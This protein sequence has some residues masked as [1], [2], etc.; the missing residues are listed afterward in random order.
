V[1]KATPLLLEK[2]I[3]RSLPRDAHPCRKLVF[4]IKSHD[5][6]WGGE[7]EDRGTY[8]GSFTWFDVGK[9]KIRA[10]D[11]DAQPELQRRVEGLRRPEEAARLVSNADQSSEW[12]GWDS[13]RYDLETI[14]P[15]F[16][17]R[18]EKEELQRWLSDAKLEHPPLPH[19]RML[20]KNL[21]AVREMQDREIVWR[22]DDDAQPEM[23]EAMG[24]GP[25]TGN[26]DFV[27]SLEI[28]DVV[29]VWARARFPGWANIAEELRVDMYWAV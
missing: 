22:W 14:D 21:T 13:L 15:R 29:T 12:D 1:E 6:G 25:E 18:G 27:R 8:S 16:R 19:G 4:H 10:V 20:Q 11:V 28:G 9:E 26:G 5:Q 24:R 7:R 17:P 3:A 2:W 23:L